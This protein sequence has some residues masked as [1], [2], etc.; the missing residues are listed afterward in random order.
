[1]IRDLRRH[2]LIDIEG[3]GEKEVL[4]MHRSLQLN[5]L[6]QMDDNGTEA[7]HVFDLVVNLTRRMF[8]RQSPIQF[9][10]ND[11][12]ERCRTYSIQVMSVLGV[13]NASTHPPECSI[14]YALL[15]SDVSNYLWECNSFNDA[16]RTSNAAFQAC[17]HLTGTHEGVRADIHTICGAVRD[18]FGIS[19]RSKGLFHLEMSVALR[20]QH[21]N[22]TPAADMTEIDVWNYA[23]AWGNMTS[24]L[25]DHGC[26]EDTVLYADLA[27]KIKTKLLGQGTYW[28]IYA[29]YEPNRHKHMALAAL[30]HHE[31]A[32]T[33]EAD[34][35]DCIK[36]PKYKA[37]MIQYFYMHANIA[38]MNGELARA[39][40]SLQRVLAM[41]IEMFGPTDRS[42]L[43]TYYLIAMV[44]LKRDNPEAAK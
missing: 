38:M 14:D 16:L 27:I 43:D 32:K 22:K 17:R 24:I 33:W 7:Q 8:P 39:Y 28:A 18:Q 2:N 12:W 37:I 19:E 44:E 4:I 1:M 35:L 6:H 11:N 15:L 25:L 10:Q 31:Q 9:P 21:M 40:K 5:L 30:G 36:D 13:H 26:F 34:P 3:C 29:C 23:N 20:Q 42:T 41:R